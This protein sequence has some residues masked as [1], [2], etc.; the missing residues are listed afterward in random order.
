MYEDGLPLSLSA[1]ACL[2]ETFDSDENGLTCQGLME[3][4]SMAKRDPEAIDNSMAK[5]YQDLATQCI[6]AIHSEKHSI[7]V[8]QVK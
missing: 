1:Y 4:F 8:V 7:E 2:L 3:F 6:I 5:V